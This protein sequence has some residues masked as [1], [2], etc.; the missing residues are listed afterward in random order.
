[1]AGQPIKTAD[2]P[3]YSKQPEENDH[4]HT[5]THRINHAN[6]Y[7]ICQ[8]LSQAVDSTNPI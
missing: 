4:S 8:L 6:Q 2:S 7:E 3:G 1:M 5:H